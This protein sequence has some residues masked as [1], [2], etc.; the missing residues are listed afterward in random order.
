MT[1]RGKQFTSASAPKAGDGNSQELYLEG[2]TKVETAS[3]VEQAIDQAVWGIASSIDIYNCN[4]ETIRNADKIR[5]F[6]KEL[7]EL[8]K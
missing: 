1:S 4:P 2:R 5:Q 6:V 3:I 7:C 8:L